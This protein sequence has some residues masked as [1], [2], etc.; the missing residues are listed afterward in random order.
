M[1]RQPT[2]WEK[3]FEKDATDKELVSKIDKQLIQFN[4]YKNNNNNNNKKMGRR[5]K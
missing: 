3:I 5:P 1:K 4:I 2:A